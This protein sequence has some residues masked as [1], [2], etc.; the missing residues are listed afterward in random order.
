MT[1]TIIQEKKN[2]TVLT[3]YD[4]DPVPS[5]PIQLDIINPVKSPEKILII[6]ALL[7]VQRKARTHGKEVRI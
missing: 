1:E 5:Y 7:V 6:R 2:L 3:G 4:H